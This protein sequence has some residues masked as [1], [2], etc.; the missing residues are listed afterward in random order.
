MATQEQ[1]T[2]TNQHRRQ[3]RRCQCLAAKD[4]LQ[5]ISSLIIP[6]VLG[7]F[8]IVITFHQQ[9]MIREQRLEDLNESRY[10][11]LEDLN[12]LREQR[13]V[14]E[15]T[16]NRS[17]EF[18]RQL[19]TERYRDE[20]LV[21]YINDMATLLEKRN[22]SLTADE[23]TATVA[24]AKTLTILRQLDTQRNIQIVRFLYEAKQL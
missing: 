1:A 11:R 5:W 10:Q 9:K 13:Q 17:N 7:I 18:Q 12:E 3:Y 15:E 8:T 24:R 2:Q 19:T 21:A 23:V 6:L 20:L 14:E 4:A 16:A 22:G